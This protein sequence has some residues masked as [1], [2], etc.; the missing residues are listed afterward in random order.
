MN[1]KAQME[2]IGIVVI[3]ILV[4]LGM[5]FMAQF[6]FKEDKT[7]KV[8]TA[9]GLAASTLGALFKTTVTELDCV[10]QFSEAALP[11]IGE[12]LLEDCALNWETKDEPIG[13]LYTCGGMHTCKFLE[14]R[15]TTL[16]NDT[17][18]EWGKKYQF[19]AKLLVSGGTD[20]LPD[21]FTPI[22]SNKGGCPKT[23]GDRDCSSQ[24]LSTEAGQVLTELCI[25]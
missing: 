12:E 3:V 25:C 9:Q 23:Q 24:P 14:I 4:T 6:A 13:S 15:A 19:S 11:A 22:K 21:L 10:D 17:L 1:K 2:M 7:K 20:Q 5:L 18:G 8:F 16:L